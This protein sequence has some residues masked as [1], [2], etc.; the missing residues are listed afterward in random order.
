LD[1]YREALQ[2]AHEQRLAVW[3]ALIARDAA[4]L[5]V[6]EGNVERGL[7]LLDSGITKCHQSGDIAN[8]AVSLANLAQFFEHDGHPDVAATIYGGTYAHS[9][10]VMVVGID[11]SI[12]RLRLALGT[13][14]LDECYA[15]GAAKEMGDLVRYA[16]GEIELARRRF[17]GHPTTED[18]GS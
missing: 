9:S 13:S 7:A 4:A 14:R 16:R 11:E 3:E 12:D 2:F 8:L 5:E 18:P 17:E 6:A 1:F 10:T 15:A